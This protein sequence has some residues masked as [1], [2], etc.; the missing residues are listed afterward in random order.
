MLNIDK[1]IQIF[2]ALGNKTRFKIFQNIF[3]CDIQ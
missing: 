1:K 2:K 3:T